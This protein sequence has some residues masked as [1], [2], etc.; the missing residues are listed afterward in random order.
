MDLATI[1]SEL[2]V[3]VPGCRLQIV[4]NPSPCVQH[5]LV[6]DAEHAVLV[7]TYL[8]DFLHFDYCSNVTGVDWLPKEL[9]EKIKVK[10]TVDGPNGPEEKE[11]DEVRK[12]SVPGYLE[13]VYHLFSTTD[14]TGPLP[15]RMRTAGR[16]VGGEATLLPSLT[17]VWRSCEFQERE[18][19]DLF[20]IH[21]EGHPDLRR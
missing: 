15:L 21:F 8:Q 14:R 1:Q 3:S 2:E 7:A 5:S 10:K 16:E 17:P 11:V 20:G 6:V 18:V 4:D 13:V 12:T 9:S 19:Y